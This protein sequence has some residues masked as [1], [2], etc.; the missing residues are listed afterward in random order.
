MFLETSI[1]KFVPV[2]ADGVIQ[3][4]QDVTFQV[5]NSVGSISYVPPS[6]GTSKEIVADSGTHSLIIQPSVSVR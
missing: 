6:V 2:G 5:A 1:D 4:G 3:S